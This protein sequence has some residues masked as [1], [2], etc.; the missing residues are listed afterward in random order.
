MTE[1]SGD[2]HTVTHYHPINALFTYYSTAVWRYLFAYAYPG[3]D[4]PLY[5]LAFIYPNLIL[6]VVNTHR[7]LQLRF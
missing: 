3:V 7:F 1:K 4:L 2:E 6:F 5:G